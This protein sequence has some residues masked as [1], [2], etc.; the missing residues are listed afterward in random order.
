MTPEELKA[1]DNPDLEN[2][3]QADQDGSLQRSIVAYLDEWKQKIADA[4]REGL[5]REEFEQL[6]RLNVSI[7]TAER[8]VDFFAKIRARDNPSP[9][10]GAG[11]L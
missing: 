1:I 8:V 2:A 10:S 5:P 7:A 11:I 3:L 6:N 9:P 4:Q